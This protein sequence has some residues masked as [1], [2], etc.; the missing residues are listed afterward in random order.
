MLQLEMGNVTK[1][2]SIFLWASLLGYNCVAQQRAI[3]LDSMTVKDVM[4]E[5]IN[6]FSKIGWKPDV[7]FIE[8][9]RNPI[10]DYK[11]NYKFIKTGSLHLFEYPIHDL[12]A[13]EKDDQLV[14]FYLA[15]EFDTSLI[16]KISKD[17]GSQP[18]ILSMGLAQETLSPF[19][20]SWKYLD[21]HI[22]LR[23]LPSNPRKDSIFFRPFDVI[24]I[25]KYELDRYSSY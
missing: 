15:V 5:F 12:Y 23:K 25:S 13:Y 22:H 3:N 7:S 24:I 17:L 4:T 1:I 16:D 8:T 14:S 6:P 21:Y 2:V 18:S 10:F 11:Y 20:W 19:E 9:S